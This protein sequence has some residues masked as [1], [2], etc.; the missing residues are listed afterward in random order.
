MAKQLKLVKPKWQ[1]VLVYSNRKVDDVSWPFSSPAQQEKAWRALF[2][3][4]RD[5]WGVYGDLEAEVNV[6]EYAGCDHACVHHNPAAPRSRALRE[7]RSQKLLY[8]Q[9][10]CGDLDSIERLLELRKD[11]EYEGWHVLELQA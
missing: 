3:L 1:K 8:E 7:A 4:L 6:K 5:E 10:K 9:A 2:K 11:Y